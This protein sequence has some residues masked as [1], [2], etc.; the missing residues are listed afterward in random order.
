MHDLVGVNDLDA[1]GS[2]GE[3]LELTLDRLPIAHQ[4]QAHT[5]L[6]E[7]VEGSTHRYLR[8]VIPAH[9]IYGDMHRDRICSNP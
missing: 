9:H 8:S 4:E 3:R 5:C 1:L 2:P 7:A 6:A